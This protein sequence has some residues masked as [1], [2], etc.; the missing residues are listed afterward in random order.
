MKSLIDWLS[1]PTWTVL[2]L[3]FTISSSKRQ[4]FDIESVQM[5]KRQ[6]K[7]V[8]R[9]FFSCFSHSTFQFIFYFQPF[10]VCI[11]YMWIIADQATFH[12]TRILEINMKIIEEV[13][14]HWFCR[15]F[16]YFWKQYIVYDKSNN[17]IEINTASFV[18]TLIP[19]YETVKVKT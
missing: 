19:E 3:R 1:Q 6:F 11:P 9:N 13:H 15:S 18:L 4:S 7:S 2:S 14:L 8:V 5:F 12:Q 16:D 10:F 17:K